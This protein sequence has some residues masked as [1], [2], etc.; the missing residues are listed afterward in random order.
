[1]IQ[2][3]NLS[4]HYG[5]VAAVDG[6]DFTVQPGIV[7]GFL[8]PNGAGKSTSMRV[9][10]GLDK[11]DSGRATINGKDYRD[12]SA[13][14]HEIGAL[15]E[16]KSA[17]GSRTARN[18]LRGLAATHGIGDARVDEVLH[19]VGLTDV[20]HHRLRT[21]SLG[22]SQ[23]LGIAMAL[24]GDPEVVM[25]DEPTNGLDPDGIKWIRELLRGLAAEG[26]T[27]FV[28]SHLMSEMALTADHLIVVGGGR[29]LAD[30]S[31]SD[32]VSNASAGTVLVR[33]PKAQELRGFIGADG[34][35]VTS[36]SATEL[37]VSGRTA[38]SIGEIAASAGLAL[39]ELATRSPSLEQAF[40]ELTNSAVAY[41]GDAGTAHA[42]VTTAIPTPD[43]LAKDQS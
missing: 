11:A 30:V 35:T 13:P 6:M 14:I 20:A 23:R 43:S 2:V 40:M 38:A 28:S 7:T 21:F 9:I 19:M 8:G 29:V 1:M 27:V 33:A 17:E 36:T 4:K 26:R 24:L 3:E 25:L 16:A 31:M 15:L 10:L 12:L 22:M 18:Q 5:S 41:H 34:V 32:F 37:E 42:A 39:H